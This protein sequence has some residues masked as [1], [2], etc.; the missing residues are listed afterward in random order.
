LSTLNC[1]ALAHRATAT[2]APQAQIAPP[3]P[4]VATPSPYQLTYPG[5]YCANHW[6]R[7]SVAANATLIANGPCA[8][9]MHDRR[10]VHLL[11]L[12]PV[13][14]GGSSI[15]CATQQTLVPQR[16]WSNMGHDAAKSGWLPLCLRS[17]SLGGYMTQPRI[18]ISVRNPYAYWVSWAKWNLEPDHPSRSQYHEL[19]PLPFDSGTFARFLNW[20]RTEHPTSQSAGIATAC[21]LPCKPDY[22]LRT[23]TLQ[24][25]WEQLLATEGL[26]PVPLPRINSETCHSLNDRW[27]GIAPCRGILTTAFTSEAIEHVHAMDS[28]MFEQP[29]NYVRLSKV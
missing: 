23:E 6:W 25:D 1:A 20:S 10:R 7:N 21:G 18:V 2:L 5:G 26:P 17:C 11:Y 16:V 24:S 9:C 14:T 4:P 8:L 27:R 28:A 19:F 3:S 15:E 29:W 22:I 12:H 13:K